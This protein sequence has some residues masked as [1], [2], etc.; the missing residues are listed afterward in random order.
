MVFKAPVNVLNSRES[1]ILDKFR[2][3]S[4]Q[5]L[6]PN[7]IL[8]TIFQLDLIRVSGYSGEIFLM[9]SINSTDFPKEFSGYEIQDSTS[10]VFDGPTMRVTI[11]DHEGVFTHKHTSVSLQLPKTI[12]PSHVL[13][14]FTI[15]VNN[16]AIPRTHVQSLSPGRSSLPIILFLMKFVL[17]FL[18]IL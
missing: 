7:I 16:L 14:F 8:L 13:E 17:N 12:C 4:L 6:D 9:H 15:L 5:S 1:I 10:V 2:L 18:A 3:D 11:L